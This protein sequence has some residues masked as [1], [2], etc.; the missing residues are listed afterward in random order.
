MLP[1]I[2]AHQARSKVASDVP[3]QVVFANLEAIIRRNVLSDLE[4]YRPEL[5]F[6]D[7]KPVKE[8]FGDMDFDYIRFFSS[9]TRFA[10][11]WSQYEPAGAWGGF[12]VFRHRRD[13][14]ATAPRT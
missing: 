4:K 14:A 12:Q 10:A 6:V 13:D 2:A 7:T 8:Y 9:D 1:A 5:V 11:Y 3:D